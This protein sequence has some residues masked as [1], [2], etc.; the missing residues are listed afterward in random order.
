MAE[1]SQKRINLPKTMVHLIL[2]SV[3]TVIIAGTIFSAMPVDWEKGCAT[4]NA[5]DERDGIVNR[6]PGDS[7]EIVQVKAGD[8]Q[9]PVHDGVWLNLLAHEPGILFMGVLPIA[10]SM[11]YMLL[12][13][14]RLI[15]G[16]MCGYYRT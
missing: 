16:Y 2:A 8:C 14:V 9:E 5:Y 3:A 15:C 4:Y 7:F 1:S 11:V 6:L 12:F 10:L 13:P